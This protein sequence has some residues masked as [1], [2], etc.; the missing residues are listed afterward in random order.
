MAH[1]SIRTTET[2]GFVLHLDA[3]PPPSPFPPDTTPRNEQG[4]T[5][6]AQKT[7]TF[8]TCTDPV[9]SQCV[10]PF[11]PAHSPKEKEWKRK[12]NINAC[13]SMLWHQSAKVT[14]PMFGCTQVGL[15]HGSDS[16]TSFQKRFF[17]SCCLPY[18]LPIL[19]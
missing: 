17:V 4:T 7:Q 9:P 19:Q 11:W 8:D 1:S 6:T 16:F 12:T 3:R 14:R 2:T 18:P 13:I 5:E 10:Q 15:K